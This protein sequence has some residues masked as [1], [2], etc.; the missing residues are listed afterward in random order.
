MKKYLKRKIFVDCFANS[1]NVVIFN[2]HMKS[3]QT[4]SII[5]ADLEFLLNK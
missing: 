1:K 5:Y 4:L 3:N 2:K